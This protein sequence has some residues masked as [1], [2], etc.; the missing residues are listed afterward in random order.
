[1]TS[2]KMACVPGFTSV[3]PQH[4]VLEIETDFFV[5]LLKL[6]NDNLVSVQDN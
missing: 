5:I 3:P 6:S 2:C 4:L 1:M